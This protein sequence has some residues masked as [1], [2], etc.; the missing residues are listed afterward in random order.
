MVGRCLGLY[1]QNCASLSLRLCPLFTVVQ[2]S[3]LRAEEQPPQKPLPR[4]PSFDDA[5]DVFAAEEIEPPGEISTPA[6]PAPS[7]PP[8]PT[9]ISPLREA[10]PNDTESIIN[11]ESRI[12]NAPTVPPK[13]PIGNSEELLSLLRQNF[14]QLERSLYTQL[15][16]TPETSLNDLRRVFLS[17]GQGTKKRLKAWQEK[18]LGS[19]RSKALGDLVAI[20]PVWWKSGYYVVPGGS[21]IVR[22]KDW[23]SLIAHTLRFVKN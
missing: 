16:K 11:S 9:P 22:E 19:A 5:Y 12:S 7:A 23:G 4:L 1:G 6:T 14:Q 21:I 10:F 3:A 15:A 20:E 2:E 8:P 17:V 13:N 18:H